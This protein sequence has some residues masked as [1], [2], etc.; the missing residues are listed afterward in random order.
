MIASTIRAFEQVRAWIALLSLKAQ[1]VCL[2]ICFAAPPKFS[3]VLRFVWTIALD[4]LGALDFAREDC[5]FPPPAV[6]ALGYAWV[7]VRPSNSSDISANVKALI[8]EALSFASA[9]MIPNVDP[10]N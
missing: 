10:D 9:L 6:F 4:I 1:R 3:V 2:F 8:D 5:V 7:H